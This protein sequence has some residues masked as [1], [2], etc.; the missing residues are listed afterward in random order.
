MKAMCQA[1]M[2]WYFVNLAHVV[3]GGEYHT[4][5]TTPERVGLVVNNYVHECYNKFARYDPLRDRNSLSWERHPIRSSSL[6]TVDI[7]LKCRFSSISG[8]RR[9]TVIDPYSQ[10]RYITCSCLF[11][12]RFIPCW[13]LNCLYSFQFSALWILSL[14]WIYKSLQF[15]PSYKFSMM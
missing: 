13:I 5:L 8:I 4:S 10:M 15:L 7:V 6:T 1:E 12:N 2:A 9:L 14:S 3:R 11:D